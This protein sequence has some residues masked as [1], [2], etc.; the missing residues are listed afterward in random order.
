MIIPYCPNPVDGAPPGTVGD[1][2][3]LGEAVGEGLA[4]G[5]GLDVGEGL[6]VCAKTIVTIARYESTKATKL[7]AATLTISFITTLLHCSSL[8]F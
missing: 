4:V 7:T 6:G 5:D 8:R 1:G 2:V 3:A